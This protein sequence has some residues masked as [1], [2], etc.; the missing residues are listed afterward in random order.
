V[1]DF[2]TRIAAGKLA[3]RAASVSSVIC[4]QQFSLRNRLT[5]LRKRLRCSLATNTDSGLPSSAVAGAP[6]IRAA[7]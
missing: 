1:R 5:R 2:S 6:I 7:T 3:W 4:T